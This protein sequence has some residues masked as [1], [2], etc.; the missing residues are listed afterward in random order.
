MVSPAPRLSGSAS[1][2]WFSLVCGF[3]AVV[4]GWD[5]TNHFGGAT[6]E[7]LVFGEA[8]E[9]YHAA[10]T[11]WTAVLIFTPMECPELMSVVDRLNQLNLRHLRV[12]GLLLV[13]PRRFP[14]WK[15]L[16]AA[17]L[18][19]FPVRQVDPSSGNRALKLMGNMRTPVLALFDRKQELRLT[20]DLA[21]RPD[22]VNLI[23]QAVEL[24][25]RR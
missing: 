4:A 9:P 3:G 15:D 20:S 23:R 2:L 25:S 12:R 21:D 17:N 7:E 18:I 1:L 5:L 13:E 22:L 11:E 6:V 24:D 16:L 14:G 10:R 8:D 19:A